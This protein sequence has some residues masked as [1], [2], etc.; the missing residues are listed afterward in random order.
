MQNTQV[1]SNFINKKGGKTLHLKSDGDQLINYKTVIARH[2]GDT[3]EVFIDYFSTTTSK[4]QFDL[5]KQLIHNGDTIALKQYDNDVI[6]L[7]QVKARFG[8]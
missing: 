7:K 3:V 4:I 5:L 2:N 1:I 8:L 6:R